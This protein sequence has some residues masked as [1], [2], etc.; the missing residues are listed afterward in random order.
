MVHCVTVVF[1]SSGLA[2]SYLVFRLSGVVSGPSGGGNGVKRFRALRS[3]FW[4]QDPERT[5]ETSV[6]ETISWH[7]EQDELAR[8]SHGV[9]IPE[10]ARVMCPV[11]NEG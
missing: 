3:R 8:G 10:H 9:L 1:E 6:D 11:R 5:V 4:K 2:L 7:K